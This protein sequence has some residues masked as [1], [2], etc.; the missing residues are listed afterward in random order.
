MQSGLRHRRRVES[1][2]KSET[3]FH[4]RVIKCADDEVIA[5][6]TLRTPR[7]FLILIREPLH[8]FGPWNVRVKFGQDR[9]RPGENDAGN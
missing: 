3:R 5:I 6:V 1:A 4:R 8:H 9:Q 7:K 2:L